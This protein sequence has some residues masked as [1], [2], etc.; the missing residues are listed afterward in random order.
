MRQHAAK[1]KLS[2]SLTYDLLPESTVV[3]VIGSSTSAISLSV[4]GS[5]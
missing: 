3:V 1:K 5:N 4:Q 2:G